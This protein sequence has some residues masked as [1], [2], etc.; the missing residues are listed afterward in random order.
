[1]LRQ[2]CANG[3]KHALIEAAPGVRCLNGGLY[4]AGRFFFPRRWHKTDVTNQ[5]IRGERVRAK[6]SVHQAT[7]GMCDGPNSQSPV[8]H[9]LVRACLPLDC[10]LLSCID[11]CTHMAKV[12]ID[13]PCEKKRSRFQ[14]LCWTKTLKLLKTSLQLSYSDTSHPCEQHLTFVV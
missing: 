4:T 1:M 5:A 14:G 7:P 13:E 2:A 3:L 12:Q 11:C 6:T 10:H 9:L 8:R